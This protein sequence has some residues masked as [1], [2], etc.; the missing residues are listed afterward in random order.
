MA[1]GALVMWAK[2]ET[3]GVNETGLRRA[4]TNP[5]IQERDDQH[6]TSKWSRSIER[7]R[8]ADAAKLN[9]RHQPDP[10]IASTSGGAPG[11][12]LADSPKAIAASATGA[13]KRPSADTQPAESES[14]MKGCGSGNL[15]S[16]L[17]RGNIAPSSL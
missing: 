11:S 13:A 6:P 10:T 12:T 9:N 14:W 5:A 3:D 8:S 16:P 1:K 17:E 15:Y 2:S 7:C 4:M